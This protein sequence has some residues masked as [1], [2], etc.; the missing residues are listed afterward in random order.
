MTAACPR[1]EVEAA[2]RHYFLTGP[3]GED[4]AAWSRLF[5][6][7]ATYND[8]FWGTFHGPAEI[9]RF[10]EGTMSFAAHVYSPLVWY[11]IDGAQVVYK[12]VNRAD[13]PE[14]G[15]DPIE[16]PSL[17]VIKYAGDGQWASEDDWWT[18]AEMRLFNQRYHAARDRAGDKA[19]DPLSRLD[20]DAAPGGGNRTDWA[21]PSA[22][23]RPSPSWLGRDVRPITRLS[24]ID[25][26]VRHPLAAPRA[27]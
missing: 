18:V 10:L 8:H 1:D 25:V 22:G 5:T 16:F 4:W 17:Q 3:V 20:W 13:N 24:D 15:G 19:R 11:N 7:D 12:V 21:R 9:Q 26:G 27:R 14:P 2:F 23:H 6:P